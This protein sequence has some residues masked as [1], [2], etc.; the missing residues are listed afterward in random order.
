M[1]KFEA[2]KGDFAKTGWAKAP[3]PPTPSSLEM[4]SSSMSRLKFDHCLL[5]SDVMIHF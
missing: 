5:T 3:R 4:V 2:K 1:P